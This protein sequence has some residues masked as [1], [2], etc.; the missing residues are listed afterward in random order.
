MKSEFYIAGIILIILICLLFFFQIR[1]RR[2][3]NKNLMD[4]ISKLAKQNTNQISKFD[5]CGNMIIGMDDRSGHILFFKS[6]KT[7]NI[8]IIINLS[9]ME[10]CKISNHIKKSPPKNKTNHK[11][12]QMGILLKPYNS[13][14]PE[15][16]LCFKCKEDKNEAV[17]RFMLTYKWSYLINNRIFAMR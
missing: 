6:E 16:Y 7:E 2:K 5:L 3:K 15:V 8:S 13:N 14:K 10:S 9:D 12:D 4:E 1:K 17:K 11:E